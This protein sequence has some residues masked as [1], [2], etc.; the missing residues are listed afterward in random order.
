MKFYIILDSINNEDKARNAIV[1]VILYNNIV[2]FLSCIRKIFKV[3]KYL[4]T[5]YLILYKSI[6]YKMENF[7]GL[8]G[9]EKY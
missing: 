3:T 6:N 7:F 4:G 9:F 2:S 5:S 1:G 8:V